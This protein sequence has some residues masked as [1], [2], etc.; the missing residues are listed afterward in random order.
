M[1]PRPYLRTSAMA[2]AIHHNL[3]L[4]EAAALA[5]DVG[6]GLCDRVVDPLAVARGGRTDMSGMAR[7]RF[8]TGLCGSP[9]GRCVGGRACRLDQ[10]RP[11]CCRG[12]ES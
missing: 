1:P 7:D 5:N 6:E 8:P 9:A 11:S 10:V 12:K 4:E 3:T 2:Y